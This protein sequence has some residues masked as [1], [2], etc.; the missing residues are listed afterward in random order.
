VRERSLTDA[1]ARGLPA[2]KRGPVDRRNPSAGT[3]ERIPRHSRHLMRIR[4]VVD[5]AKLRAAPSPGADVARGEPSPGADVAAVRPVLVQM[6]QR[7]AQSRCAIGVSPKAQSC[8]SF[9]MHARRLR[10]KARPWACHAKRKGANVLREGTAFVHT[11]TVSCTV[12]LHGP[13]R[14]QRLKAV[15]QR[16]EILVL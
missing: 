16:A 9:G 6:W 2:E 1:F 3:D 12:V 14:G 5:E 4:R 10:C 15:C 7:C 11:C 13:L 8:G